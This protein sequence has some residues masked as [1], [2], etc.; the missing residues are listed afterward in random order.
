MTDPSKIKLSHTQRAAFE[1]RWMIDTVVVAN[2]SIG[3]ATQFEQA[4]PVGIIP[5]QAGDFQSENDSH[6]SQRDFASEA[7]EPGAFVDAGAGQSQIFVDDGHLLL[8]PA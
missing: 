4:I 6:V 5:R 7:S 3:D 1:Q 8:G 2:E